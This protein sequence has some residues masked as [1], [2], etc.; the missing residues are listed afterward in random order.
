[1]DFDSLGIKTQALRGVDHKVPNVLSLVSLKLNDLTH[2]GVVHDSAIAGK[3]LLDHLEN[4]FLVKLLRETLDGSQ[5][6]SSIS[7]LD[8]YMDIILRLLRL[9]GIFVGFG[10]GVCNRFASV[11]LFSTTITKR[12]VWLRSGNELLELRRCPAHVC[13]NNTIV[14]AE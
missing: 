10:E 4:L 1:V 14:A 2:L 12:G 13:R 9:S 8:T 11:F 5:G 7:L 6:L 3:L